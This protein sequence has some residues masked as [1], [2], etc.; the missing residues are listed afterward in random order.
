MFDVRDKL[1]N[2]VIGER[3]GLK[4]DVVIEKGMLGW[5]G[6][7]ERIHENFLLLK[8]VK[9]K[10]K[11]NKLHSVI[12]SFVNSVFIKYL[13]EARWEIPSRTQMSVR[14]KNNFMLF[15]LKIN[16]SLFEYHKVTNTSQCCTKRHIH[17]DKQLLILGSGHDGI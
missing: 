13:I 8:S 17:F 14:G 10:K 5:F 11:F 6:H 12:H 4:E 16:N 2:C 9:N 15:K 1:R 7:L 3:C